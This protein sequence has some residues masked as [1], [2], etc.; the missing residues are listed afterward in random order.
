MIDV[1]PPEARVLGNGTGSTTI[2]TSVE[3]VW[4]VMAEWSSEGDARHNKH[5]SRPK[6]AALHR[7]VRLTDL[8]LFSI[9]SLYSIL[10]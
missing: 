6:L 5:R 4:R 9:R 3:G 8:D 10:A 1:D 7:C 2:T